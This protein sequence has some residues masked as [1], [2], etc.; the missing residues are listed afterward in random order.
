MQL[1]TLAALVA[2]R[3]DVVV[4]FEMLPRR[5]QSSLDQW[6][7]G[8]LDERAFLEAV[9]W[10]SVWGMPAD[11]YLP[12]FRFVRLH[13]LP[14]AAINVDRSLVTRVGD[15]GWAALTADERSGLA[16]P[17]P[18]PA[19]YRAWLA[20]VF[21]DH[22]DED[23]PIDVTAL[24]R[25]VDAQLVWDR[26]FAEGIVAAL[27]RHPDAV[28]A[29]IVGGGHVQHGWGIEHQLADLG[30]DDVLA[31]LP[32]DAGADC[33][34]L[35]AGIADAVFGVEPTGATAADPPRLG[36]LIVADERGVRAA[37]VSTGGIAAAAGVE[38]GDVILE[39]AG[40]AIES[41]A[42]LQEIVARQAPGTWLPLRIARGEREFEKIARF[43]PR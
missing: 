10:P 4:A 12:L 36:I 13:R 42:D 43:P 11:L 37:H 22:T 7:A 31:L 25:F 23:Q 33:N 8:E 17:A 2:A 40:V 38:D 29:A 15:V 27:E 21:G 34:K 1:H 20:E 35:V 3:D 5:A 6:V 26:A 9:D 41:P 16:D 39:A 14:A 24:D 19:P 30:I 28:V 32:W 18:A